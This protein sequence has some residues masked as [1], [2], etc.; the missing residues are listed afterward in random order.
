MRGVDGL[1][2]LRAE[3]LTGLPQLAD[4]G[5]PRR[6]G[7]RRAHA[8]RRRCEAVRIGLVGEEA[9]Q[10]WV[11]QRRFDLVVRLRGR[12]A[13][14]DRGDPRAA[15]RRPR[16]HADPARPARRHRARRSGPA[17]SGARPAAG[18]SP[19]R[20]PST[21]ATSGARP[22]TVRARARGAAHA[23]RRLLRRR[24][25]PGREPG[26]RIARAGD[27]DR[28]ARSSAVFVLL[29]R[30]ARLG[31][32]GARDP[33]HRCRS[34]SSAASSRCSSPARPGTCRRWSA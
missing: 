21:G 25:R 31:A 19:S 7:A 26:A 9:S 27:R 14:H 16:R 17:R 6:R 30:R 15:G 8:R 32:R 12:P 33:R 13:R 4:R 24:R 28:H 2:D 20:R 18:A 10:V 29:L 23:A 22:P 3:Q 5:R 11:G 1:A 34:P